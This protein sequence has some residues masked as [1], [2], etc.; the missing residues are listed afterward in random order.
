LDSADIKP[1]IDN[2][3]HVENAAKPVFNISVGLSQVINKS[4][5]VL[6]GAS[7]DFTSYETTDESNEL[8][9]GFGGSDIYH[10][11]SGISYNRKKSSLCLGFSYAMSPAKHI[12]PY[13][14]INQTPEFTSSARIT[15]QMYSIILG[16]TYYLSK[17][18]E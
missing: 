13:T 18:S 15:S 3:L 9:H 10:F 16:Y 12:P 4:F 2:F 7:T 6:I 1:A 17:L 5:S 11:S 14:V 8:L